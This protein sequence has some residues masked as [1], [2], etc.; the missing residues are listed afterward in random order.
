M[1]PEFHPPTADEEQMLLYWSGELDPIDRD[2][3]EA[4]LARDPAA[5]QQLRELQDLQRAADELPVFTRRGY[6]ADKVVPV[7]AMPSRSSRNGSEGPSMLLSIPMIACLSLAAAMLFLL[8]IPT[9]PGA[10]SIDRIAPHTLL[11]DYVVSAP[12]A[13]SAIMNQPKF[14][15][16]R[17]GE[18][19]TRRRH[20]HRSPSTYLP[21]SQPYP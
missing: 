11:T 21:S 16:Q 19:R 3:A 12:P 20:L 4:L 14:L 15:A 1:N 10:N 8:L 18:F 17:S 7:A 9:Q 6:T 13:V 2:R 5:R